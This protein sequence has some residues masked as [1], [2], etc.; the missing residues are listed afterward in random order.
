MGGRVFGIHATDVIRRPLARSTGGNRFS[1]SL[2]VAQM[3]V[4]IDQSGEDEKS[5][6][7]DNA[8]SP[9]FSF[10]RLSMRG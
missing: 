10:L 6:G 5:L 9:D 1:S 2:P 3:N 7:V 4:H 8:V